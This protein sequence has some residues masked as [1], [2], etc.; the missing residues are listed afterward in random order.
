MM[1]WVRQEPR[2]RI[3]ICREDM[4]T[5]Q[6]VRLVDIFWWPELL[7]VKGYG[8]VE[9]FRGEMGSKGIRQA[10]PGSTVGAKQALCQ[11][12]QVHIRARPWHGYDPEFRI[13]SDIS[14]QLHTEPG[15][16][17]G[18]DLKVDRNIVVQ[19]TRVSVRVALWGIRI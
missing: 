19:G 12:P 14:L 4:I 15:H 7:P 17:S 18:L 9:R 2:L 6:D 5:Q 13:S 10:H 3:S 11:D 1:D 16:L 8:F